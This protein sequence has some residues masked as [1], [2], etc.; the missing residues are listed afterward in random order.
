MASR[1]SFGNQDQNPEYKSKLHI[2]FSIT[3]RPLIYT[4]FKKVYPSLTHT[5]V[6]LCNNGLGSCRA[7]S[8]EAES[9]S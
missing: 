2:V 1:Y 9:E 7:V 3:V 6:Q 5:F 4:F 8:Y